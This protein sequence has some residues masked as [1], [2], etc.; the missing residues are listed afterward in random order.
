M[1]RTG[2][3][4]N[5]SL[6]LQ[7]N[8]ERKLFGDIIRAMSYFG[9]VE[10]YR[11]IGFG[12][13]YFKDFSMFYEDFV[14]TDGISIEIDNALYA[15]KKDIRSEIFIQFE[16]Y[17]EANRKVI[18]SNLKKA[19]YNGEKEIQDSI[20]SEVVKSFCDT[21]KQLNVFQN[22]MF[23][24]GKVYDYNNKDYK[25]IIDDSNRYFRSLSENYISNIS[26]DEIQ[27]T[28]IE[29]E[30]FSLDRDAYMSCLYKTSI[31]RYEYNKPYGFIDLR[32]G[33]ANS[34]INKID[35]SL[36][37]RNI[38]WLDYDSFIDSSMLDC[39]FSVVKK[40][41]TGSVIIFSV[42]LEQNAENRY[43]KFKENFGW[44]DDE[45]V[46]NEEKVKLAD[47]D[48][49]V[50]HNTIY[51]MV[52]ATVERAL[53]HKN[54]TKSDSEPEYQVQ[55]VLNCNYNDGT[56]MFT[57]ALYVFSYTDSEGL[58]RLKEEEH[59]P[60][61]VL[62]K[63]DWF[64]EDESQ[65]SITIPALTSKEVSAINSFYPEYEVDDICELLPF[66]HKNTIKDYIK[67]CRYYPHFAEMAYSV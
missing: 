26:M 62:S 67:I 33:S 13:C 21:I 29:E 66:I 22:R 28:I 60:K 54:Q 52:N 59:F 6:R 39:L 27:G 34:A 51:K 7:K 50:I 10:E 48:D 49:H 41:S 14:I 16:E 8:I 15:R 32:F 40:A 11:Y 18:I 65:Y 55:Q 63:Y 46:G 12:S 61:N 35:W 5:Y 4:I 2:N 19:N 53:I 64:S 20:S 47:C 58:N 25:R 38:V 45:N 36:D 37:K 43:V 23:T 31:N 17:L 44:D 9:A 24:P 30:K 1:N 42:S 3:K 56:P 57:Y